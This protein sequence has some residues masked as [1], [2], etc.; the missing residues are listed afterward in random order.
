MVTKLHWLSL[1]GGIM[2]TF[3]FLVCILSYF[4]KYPIMNLYFFLFKKQLFSIETVKKILMEVLT[5]KMIGLGITFLM[6]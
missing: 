1:G 5:A 3:Y 6:F 4:S 2:D